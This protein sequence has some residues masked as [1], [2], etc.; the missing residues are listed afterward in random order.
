M[1]KAWAAVLA[2]GCI[3]LTGCRAGQPQAAKP[4]DGAAELAEIQTMDAGSGRLG[5]ISQ[6][7]VSQAVRDALRGEWDSW[8]RLS[9]E[10]QMVSSHFPGWCT[11]DFGSW[12][13]CEGFLG[14]SIPNP[15]EACD[16]LEQGTC[17]A[18]PLGFRDAPRVQAG[19]YGTE[20]GHV[21]WISAQAGYRNGQVRVTVDAM[22]Y[23]DPA[24]ARSPEGGWSSVELE[25]QSYLESAEDA[26]PVTSDRT[27]NYFSNTAWRARGP[28]LYRL[29]VI[30]EPDLETQVEETM[31][32]VLDAFFETQ[33]E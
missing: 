28:V 24:D 33:E 7:A 29:G 2:A 1:K 5:P 16:W 25:R 8:N 13:E 14:F 26:P 27:E 3:L 10:Q 30:G 9:W 4:A 11:R 12:A 17:A 20:D 18:M 32:Q 21:E 15:L 23:G 22:L 6:G 31:E 19:W